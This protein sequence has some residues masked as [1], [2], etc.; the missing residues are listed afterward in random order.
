MNIFW[1]N[2]FGFYYISLYFKVILLNV[3]Y[4]K[5][6]DKMKIIDSWNLKFDEIPFFVFYS[7]K[8]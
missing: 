7:L 1:S 5:I 3:Q 4:K 6:V 8:D 2:D